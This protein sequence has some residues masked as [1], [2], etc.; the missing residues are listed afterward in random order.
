MIKARVY[1]H[2]KSDCIVI[3]SDVYSRHEYEI[4]KC[5]VDEYRLAGIAIDNDDIIILAGEAALL[6]MVYVGEL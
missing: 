6:K 1:Y 3:V 2:E 5:P 4:E